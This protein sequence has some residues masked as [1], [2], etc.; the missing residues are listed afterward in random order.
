VRDVVA[1]LLGGN[2]GRLDIKSQ[3]AAPDTPP[4]PE[5]DFATLLAHIDRENAEWVRAARRINPALLVAFLE[6]T[7]PQLYRAFKALPPF[8][9]AGPAVAWAGDPQSPNWFDIAREY[10]EKWLHQQH[11]RQAVGQPLLVQRQWLFPVLDTFLRALPYTYR[12]VP[13]PEGTLVAIRI[14][15]EA[16]GDWTLVR[17]AVAWRLFSGP[18]PAAT[19]RVRLD[20]DTAW[21][22][23]TRGIGPAEA[24]ARARFKGEAAFAKPV[25]Q[26]VS[27]MA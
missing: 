3:H 11:V 15:G 20:Q 19:A 21:R 12:Q 26:M 6:L 5:P 13:A 22:L 17:Q 14:T 4:A 25:L 10:T 8:A 1:H 18:A 2:L 7:D 16:G 23:F 27:I 9:P 24:A